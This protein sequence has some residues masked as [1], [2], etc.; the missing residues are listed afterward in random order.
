M[1][2]SRELSLLKQ[3]LRRRVLAEVRALTPEE[4]LAQSR[5]SCEA[6]IASAEFARAGTVMLFA[7]MVDEPSLDALEKAVISAG[8][9]MCAPRSEWKTRSIEPAMVASL[10]D[11]VEGTLGV[12]Q[13]APEAPRVP[14]AEI[15]LIVVPG[16]AFDRRGH[17]LG[18]GAGF[19]DRFLLEVSPGT[20]LAAVALRP[21]LV[22]EVPTAPHDLPL[23]AVYGPDGVFFR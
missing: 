8:K 21:Q 13:P 11:C 18:R 3:A 1:S 16:V 23:T 2:G 9:R 12:G 20:P 10:R 4:L 17:R 15:D 5:A 22:P 14:V 7:P 19:Y 6:L